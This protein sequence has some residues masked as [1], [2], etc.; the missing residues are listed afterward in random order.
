[1]DAPPTQF[2][3]V[4]L[5]FLVQPVAWPVSLSLYKFIN[6]FRTSK[7]GLF[8]QGIFGYNHGVITHHRNMDTLSRLFGGTNRIKLIKLFLFNHEGVFDM[9]YLRIKLATEEK[10]IL[11]E[12]DALK[13]MQLVKQ[14]KISKV[15]TEKKG[16][17]IIEKKKKMNVWSFDPKF[18]YTAPLTDFLIKT[19]SIEHKAIV[20][21]IEKTGKIKA[22][23]ISGVF[24]RNPE[25]R[26]DM[27]VVGDHVSAASMEKIVRSLESEM[28]KD[29][30]YA[31]LSAPDFSYRMSMN[32][33]LVRDVLDF[34]HRVL[35]D[36][37]G[38]PTRQ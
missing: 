36:R 2:F 38:I 12:I 21:K 11:K 14:S 16:K 7:R 35:L 3:L 4:I 8:L 20:R 30:K 27:F 28:G 19:Q 10:E 1:V 33:K 31:V 34:P 26:L 22:V 6:V 24:T 18:E 29:I 25:A 9:D 23:L 37:I 32:D 15:V 17:K 5:V 13:K